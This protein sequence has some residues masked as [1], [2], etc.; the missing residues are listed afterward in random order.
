M[1]IIYGY[2]RV[3]SRDQ[4]EDRQRIAMQEAGVEEK[5]VYM[6]KQS[7]KDRGQIPLGHCVERFK[8]SNSASGLCAAQLAHPRISKTLLQILSVTTD[9]NAGGFCI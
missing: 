5:N 1:S 4:N 2:I 7:G 3:S 9:R 6:N 8:G